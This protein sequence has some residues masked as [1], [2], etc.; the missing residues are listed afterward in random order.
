M[1]VLFVVPNEESL[2]KDFATAAEIYSS[3]EPGA[4]FLLMKRCAEAGHPVA[5]FLLALMYEAGQG[6]ARS[7]KEYKLWLNRL[8]R[9]AENG[10]ALAQWEVSCNYRWG[11]HFPVDIKQANYWLQRSAE[12]GHPESQ[13]HLAWYLQTGQFDYNIDPERAR[14]WYQKALDQGHPET[15]YTEALKFFQDGKPTDKAIALLRQAADKNFKPAIEVL[16]GLTH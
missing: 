13:H 8:L 5:C 3:D 7:E 16:R 4:A 14:I 11:N 9:L 2:A 6:T 10:N 12:N 15:V 1:E